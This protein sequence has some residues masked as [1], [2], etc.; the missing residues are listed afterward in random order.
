MDTPACYNNEFV[1]IR[2]SNDFRFFLQQ[3]FRNVLV[4]IFKDKKFSALD[5]EILL[6]KN[7]DKRSFKFLETCEH[8]NNIGV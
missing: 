5:N 2:E 8:R 1:R 6:Y 4:P 3:K 7:I